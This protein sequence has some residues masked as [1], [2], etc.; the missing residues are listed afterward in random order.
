MDIPGVKNIVVEKMPSGL[1][2]DERCNNYGSFIT[3]GL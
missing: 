2:N 1:I 3:V